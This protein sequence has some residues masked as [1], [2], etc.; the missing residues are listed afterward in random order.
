MQFMKNTHPFLAAIGVAALALTLLVSGSAV[1]AESGDTLTNA[2]DA[3]V[4]FADPAAALAAGYDLLTDAAGIAC[5]DMPGQG[6]M[7]VHY[8]KG[9]LVQSGKLDPARP[10][11]L[12]YEVQEDSHLRLVALEYVVF[13]SDWDA[14]HSAPPELFGQKFMLTAAGNRFGLPAYYSLHAWIYKHNPSGRFNP[15][16]P[17]V[18]CG[19]LT[20]TDDGG[21]MGTMHDMVFQAPLGDW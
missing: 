21:T 12:V 3:T 10:Q 2:R 4:A 7:G 1:A 9:T 13:Q 18:K 19:Q 11:A 14:S 20:G 17:T 6:G 16:N 15:W 5:I 8:V